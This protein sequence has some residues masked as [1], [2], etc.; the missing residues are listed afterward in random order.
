MKRRPTREELA[1][2]FFSEMANSVG[3]DR[4]QSMAYNLIVHELI[5]SDLLKKFDQGWEAYGP[6]MLCLDLRGG[7]P[8]EYKTLEVFMDVADAAKEAGD[9]ET[10]DLMNSAVKVIKNLNY[11][12]Y[13]LV[14]RQD[15]SSIVIT[16]IDR[17]NPIGETKDLIK[18]LF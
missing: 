14:M 1:S 5:I 13:G 11:E 6:G 18:E 9:D 2:K 3:A 16:H 8:S 7:K 4:E 15:N 17:D 10:H 12:R